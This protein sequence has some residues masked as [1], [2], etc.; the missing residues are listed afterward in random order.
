MAGRRVLATM[1]LGRHEELLEIA[2]PS[3]EAYASRHGYEICLPEGD[4]APDRS[5]KQWAKVAFLNQLLPECE[6]VVWVDSDA[7]IVD[8][9][10]DMAD[11]LPASASLGLVDHHYGG[12]SV[13]NTGVMAIRG[14]AWAEEFF[15]EVWACTQYLETPWYDNAAVLHLMG[16]RLDLEGDNRECLAGPPTRWSG[17]IHLMDLAWNSIP[18]DPAP[19]P[20]IV[21]VTTAHSWETRLEALRAAARAAARA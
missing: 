10:W 9:T 18:E 16:Y 20:R 12:Q 1:G 5:H 3:F 17:G 13:P 14:G 6:M 4:P 19:E 15:A 2:L 7:V 8:P 11:E 21:H